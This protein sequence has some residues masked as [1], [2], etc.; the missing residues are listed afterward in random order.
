MRIMIVTITHHKSGCSSQF[1]NALSVLPT[2]SKELSRQGS[3][4][5]HNELS[6]LLFLCLTTKTCYTKQVIWGPHIYLCVIRKAFAQMH[7]AQ[8]IIYNICN[9]F[10]H[11]ISLVFALTTYAQMFFDCITYLRHRRYQTDACNYI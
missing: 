2:K 8:S 4:T 7:Y 11:C 6:N 3:G 5:A 9:A 1:A 10:A